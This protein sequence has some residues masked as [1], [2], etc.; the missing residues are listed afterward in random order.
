[1]LSRS[2]IKYLYTPVALAIFV[3]LSFS[4]V[5][6]AEDGATECDNEG[7][8]TNTLKGNAG[9]ES[10]DVLFC[11][12]ISPGDKSKKSFTGLKCGSETY[13]T[14]WNQPFANF[15]GTFKSGRKA[16]VTIPYS[17][18]SLPAEPA[19][20]CSRIKNVT[21]KLGPADP[22][23]NAVITIEPDGSVKA[24]KLAMRVAEIK[25]TVEGTP[26]TCF[27]KETTYL[28]LTTGKGNLK[29]L[30]GRRYDRKPTSS[31][32]KTVVLVTKSPYFTPY[33]IE[34]TPKAA[35]QTIMNMF[36]K[37]QKDLIGLSWELKSKQLIK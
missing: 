18:L 3:A 34:G 7:T 19:H 17:G 35:C 37:R 29:S 14:Q 30:I 10:G 28:T 26:A 27:S 31:N 11:T 21:I 5:A 32:Y 33:V 8:I 2:K 1:M 20:D 9:V 16:V 6:S 15:G 22:S 24:A 13:F 25:A 23:G 12:L 4:A 36:G